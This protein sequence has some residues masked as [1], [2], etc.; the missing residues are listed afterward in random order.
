[1]GCDGVTTWDGGPMFAHGGS[2]I[3]ISRGAM[4]LLIPNMHKCIK[5]YKPCWAGDIK[6]GLCLRDQGVI[7]HD[8]PNYVFNR[9]PPNNK[10]EFPTDGCK[11]PVT[12]HHLTPLQIQKLYDLEMN[13]HMN[14]THVNYG[15]IYNDWMGSDEN[16][17][18]KGNRPGGDYRNEYK[19][20]LEEC[21]ETCRKEKK[22]M[23]FSYTTEK[24]CW[25]KENIPRLDKEGTEM[26][27][28]FASKYTC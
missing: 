6:V 12:F 25:F 8:S 19:P 15:A 21:K 9:D 3:F 10:F 26:T 11:L 14:G 23:S 28:H 18:L 7:I 1:M 16:V 17:V 20:T 4:K 24:Q 2:G 5:K 22:C 13:S 27:G